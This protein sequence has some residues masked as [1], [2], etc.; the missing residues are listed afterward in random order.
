V[1]AA[2]VA[3]DD[4][5]RVLP[6]VEIV[7][8]GAYDYDARYN[9]GRSEYF[10]PARLPEVQAEAVRTAVSAVHRTLA[11]GDLS[12]V[13]VIVDGSGTVWVI[14]VNVAPGMTE[15]SL[16]PQ[17]AGS[18]VPALYAGLVGRAAARESDR[19]VAPD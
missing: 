17:A 16:F 8:E 6:L 1:A 11:L 14:D 2:V 15:T 19:H 3:T 5:V 10:V 12:R 7:T 13:D 9:A 18:E 4:D